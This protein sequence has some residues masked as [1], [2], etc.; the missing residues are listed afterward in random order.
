MNNK[1]FLILVL[2]IISLVSVNASII[3]DII[4][5][6]SVTVSNTFPNN[7]N[8]IANITNNQVNFQAQLDALTLGVFL[9]KT[10]ADTLYYNINNGNVLNSTKANNNLIIRSVNT[11]LFF[12]TFGNTQITLNNDFNISISQANTTQGGFLTSIDYNNFNNKIND[13]TSFNETKT[14]YL[15]IPVNYVS[16]LIANYTPLFNGS[17]FIN[18]PIKSFYTDENITLIYN[19]TIYIDATNDMLGVN[20]ADG[21]ESHAQAFEVKTKI[22]SGISSLNSTGV[23]DILNNVTM[24]F[25][26][27]PFNE[28]LVDASNIY[29]NNTKY[30]VYDLINSTYLEIRGNYTTTTKFNSWTYQQAPYIDVSGESNIERGY[31]I[32]DNNGNWKWAVYVPDTSNDTDL[33]IQ[34]SGQWF[35][36]SVN[37]L[38]IRTNG[39]VDVNG[40]LLFNGYYGEFFSTTSVNYVL[41]T[42]FIYYNLTEL[43][44]GETNGF[45]NVDGI[46]LNVTQAGLYN[47]NYY[48]DGL[49]NNNDDVIYRMMLN[50]VQENKSLS[51]MRY[52]TNQNDIVS[53]S[54]IKRLNVNDKIRFEFADQTR[55]GATLTLDYKN[56]N[57]IMISK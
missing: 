45:N 1:I 46:T 27:V 10:Y 34:S 12:N 47:I 39:D 2:F 52:S 43:I 9:N 50:N 49:I 20:V 16:N 40:N 48:F 15:Y 26:N 33:C 37:A 7:D 8:L 21:T 41:T 5:K 28:N 36:N 18:S 23:Y 44:T 19:D 11:P 6:N 56:I 25:S 51:N 29:F 31:T 24:F 42:R 17:V 13:N 32:S 55:N 57:I 38:C 54:L 22:R 35:N 30:Y 4:N 3:S 53:N 14:N